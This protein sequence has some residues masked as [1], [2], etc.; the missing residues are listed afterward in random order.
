MKKSVLYQH[1]AENHHEGKR[2]RF[3]VK[4]PAAEHNNEPSAAIM[5]HKAEYDHRIWI[6]LCFKLPCDS[7]TPTW[8]WFALKQ[9]FKDATLSACSLNLPVGESKPDILMYRDPVTRELNLKPSI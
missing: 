8:I 1:P 3:T 4:L 9:L 6:H 7:H 2:R 5:L